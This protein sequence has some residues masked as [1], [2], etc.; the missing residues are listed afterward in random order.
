MQMKY[1]SLGG[2]E[3]LKALQESQGIGMRL[4]KLQ[5]FLKVGRGQLCSQTTISIGNLV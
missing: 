2:F 4:Q 5:R 1:M 3:D